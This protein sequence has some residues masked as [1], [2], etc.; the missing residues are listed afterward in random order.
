MDPDEVKF[1]LD[2]IAEKIREH[3]LYYADNFRAARMW[4][5]SQRRRFRKLS[6]QGCCGCYEFVAKRWLLKKLR[7]D[8]YLC[9]CNY[10]H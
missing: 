4:K 10:G 5:S 2:A 9:G 3:D 6:E 8:L 7:F 1:C